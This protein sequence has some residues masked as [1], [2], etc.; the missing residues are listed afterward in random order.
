MSW[1]ERSAG[2]LLAAAMVVTVTGCTADSG[3]EGEAACAFEVTY[4]G[5][6]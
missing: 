5:R 4:Q 2:A 3:G 6:T 1:S